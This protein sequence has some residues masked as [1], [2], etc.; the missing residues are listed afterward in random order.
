MS[1]T[2]VEAPTNGQPKPRPRTKTE[3]VRFAI[4]TGLE[5]PKAIVAYCREQYGLE[6]NPNFAC[7]IKIRQARQPK[8]QTS[9]HSSEKIW[10]IDLPEESTPPPPGPPGTLTAAD[11]LTLARLARQAG[12]VEALRAFL[13]GLGRLA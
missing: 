13:D 5:R 4:A 1:I 10:F 9:R 8:G 12:G 6:I 11:L 2:E 3:A 7:Q